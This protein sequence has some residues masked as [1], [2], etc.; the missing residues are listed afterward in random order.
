MSDCLRIRTASRL[1]F[2]LFGWG[3]HIARQFGGIGLMV[4]SPRIE[5]TIER[6]GEWLVSG[7]LAPRADRLI[8][9]LR[10][11]LLDSGVEL[12]PVQLSV[13]AAPPEHVGLGV[14]TQLSLAIARGLLILAGRPDP[15]PV[16]LARL[17]ARG[18]RSGIGLHGF[19]HGGLIVDGGRNRDGGIPPL[20]AHAHFPDDWLVLVVQPPGR[21]GLHGSDESE[22]FDRLPPISQGAVD[23]LCRLVLLEILP[24]VF[25][26]DLAAFGAALAD[27]QERVGAAFAPA[28]GGIYAT[29][30]AASIVRELRELGFV[31]VGQS[32]WGPTLYAFSALPQSEIAPLAERLRVQFSLSPSS[33]FCTR[34]A[35]HG[36]VIERVC[37]SPAS[38]P[39]V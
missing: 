22:A 24:A 35:N 13:Q 30:E 25:D 34:A 17:T 3:P 37:S 7:A 11:R 1:H 29:P 15:S 12:P 36:A 31:G 10:R 9:E 16:E 20:L 32:S 8:T 2:G 18:A 38:P 23:V 6:A 4:D 5:L 27:L 21:C 28:Q 39:S 14:G 26:H 33:V 19:F